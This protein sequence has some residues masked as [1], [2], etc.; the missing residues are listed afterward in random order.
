MSRIQQYCFLFIIRFRN[1]K[2]IIDSNS[3][4]FGFIAKGVFMRLKTWYL[5]SNLFSIKFEN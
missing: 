2:K 5:I 1:D 3:I 4:P